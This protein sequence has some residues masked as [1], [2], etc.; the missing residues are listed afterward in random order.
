MLVNYP[1]SIVNDT[2]GLYTITWAYPVTVTGFSGG[3]GV[4]M[5]SPGSAQWETVSAVSL[6]VQTIMQ[7]SADSS[8]DDC[9]IFAMLSTP[10]N[11]TSPHP[12]DLATPTFAV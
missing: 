4:I 7:I 8:D 6:G 5:Y 3:G 9:T 10:G 11:W 12:Y 1:T 2:G